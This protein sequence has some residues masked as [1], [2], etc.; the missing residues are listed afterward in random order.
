MKLNQC[1]AGTYCY[2][3]VSGTPAGLSVYPNKND[4]GC[5]VHHYCPAGTTVEMAIPPG[6]MIKV[7]GA[8]SLSEAIQLPAGWFAKEFATDADPFAYDST[9]PATFSLSTCN[10]G[11]Y[12][13][14]GSYVQVP[15]PA[16]TFRANFYGRNVS[17]CGKC[18][19]GTYC[20]K[21]GYANPADCPTG[22]FCPEGSI[23]P[24]PCPRGTYNPSVNK[25]DSRDCTKCDPGFYCPFLG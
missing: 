10:P 5:S 12:C 14:P 3:L 23:N 2:R 6:T 17:D 13:P 19:A 9:N 15:C 18:P 8:G 21:V 25:Y 22:H 1:P 24:T 16:G 20:P 4:H 7:K 11:Y